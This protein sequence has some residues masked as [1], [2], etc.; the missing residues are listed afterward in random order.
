M[1]TFAGTT[2]LRHITMAIISIHAYMTAAKRIEI[3]SILHKKVAKSLTNA[4][5]LDL[6]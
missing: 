5:K 4:L 1:P 6:T 3:L 2:P